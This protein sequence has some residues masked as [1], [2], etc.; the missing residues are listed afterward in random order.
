MIFCLSGFG[1]VSSTNEYKVL[2]MYKLALEELPVVQVKIYTLGSGK[3]WR[4][5]GRHGN[6]LEYFY[7][8]MVFLPMD[9]IIGCSRQG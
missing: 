7:A 8:H 9:A 1:Y 3:G 4:H 5:M 6:R 2:R